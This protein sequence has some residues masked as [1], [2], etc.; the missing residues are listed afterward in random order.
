MTGL[1]V[2]TKTGP[3]GP[4]THVNYEREGEFFCLPLVSMNG[5]LRIHYDVALTIA[6]AKCG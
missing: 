3:S 1:C 2:P 5:P 4:F 6:I